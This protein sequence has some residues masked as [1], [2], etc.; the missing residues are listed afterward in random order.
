MHLTTHENMLQVRGLEYLSATNAAAFK[1]AVRPRINQAH[2]IV[3]VDCSTV[4]FIDSEGL[5]ALISIHRTVLQYEGKVR[6]A[7]TSALVHK[8]IQLIHFDEIFDIAP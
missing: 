4:R 5:G 3:E 7:H 1:E 6:L 8:L 2:P